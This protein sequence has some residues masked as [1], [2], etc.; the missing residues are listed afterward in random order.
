M[1]L[2]LAVENYLSLRDRTVLSMLSDHRVA[3][4]QTQIAT[5]GPR[6]IL[7]TIALYGANGS[8]KSNIVKAFGLLKDLV[9]KGTL[10]EDDPLPVVP[11]KLDAD[12][13]K[14]PTHVEVEFITAGVH[15]SYGFEATARHIEDEW[16]FRVELDGSEQ[17]LFERRSRKGAS[18]VLGDALS[19]DPERRRYLGYVATGTRENQLFLAEAGQKTIEE[20]APIRAFVK[21]WTIVP[22][23][24]HYGPLLIRMAMD[25][26]F[27]TAMSD[28]LH[29][30][31]T[32]IEALRL[33]SGFVDN[34][35]P[36]VLEL[37]AKAQQTANEPVY[38]VGSL[39]VRLDAQKRVEGFKLFAQHRGPDGV[40]FDLDMN[41]ESDGTRRLLN[42]A[43]L[44][45][46]PDGDDTHTLCIVD[47]LDRSLH[48]LLTKLFLQRFLAGQRQTSQLVFT[49]HDTSIL[50]FA[51]LLSRDSL[52]FIEKDPSGASI[53]Y[54]LS[55]LDQAQVDTVEQLGRGLADG[56][57]QGRFGAIPFFGASRRS[58]P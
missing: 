6:D 25:P 48:P 17:L 26:T 15:Y 41:E 38:R 50:D 32:G 29:H 2:Q 51:N 40:P 46:P 18:I 39:P 10:R 21:G 34:I 12:H 28:I 5:V 22:P 20:L 30:A 36:D 23:D 42:L 27:I 49:T 7:R 44:L 13:P 14:R 11:F 57:L 56:Y 35:G 24:R 54:P 52:G 55:E 33:D 58:T 45:H 43:P 8:G 37:I 1:L 3:H 9:L 31:G 16:L 53:T 47:E 4:Q 19:T